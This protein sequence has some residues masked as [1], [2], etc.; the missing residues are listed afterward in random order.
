MFFFQARD[1]AKFCTEYKEEYHAKMLPPLDDQVDLVVNL[2][3]TSRHEAK[4]ALLASKRDIS[5]AC[6]K[7]RPF[8]SPF[9]FLR[10]S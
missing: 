8:S 4:V 9:V 10:R 3:D 7:R 5:S 1:D 2:T 6:A